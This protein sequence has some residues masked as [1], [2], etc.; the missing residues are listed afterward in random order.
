MGATAGEARSLAAGDRV[1]V[2]QQSA[3]S[4]VKQRRYQ[5]VKV[6]SEYGLL[7]LEWVDAPPGSKERYLWVLTDYVR[8]G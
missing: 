2:V 6:N 3:R 8:L 7:Q 4:A 1:R 5:V